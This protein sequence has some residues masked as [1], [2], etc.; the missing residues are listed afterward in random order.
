MFPICRPAHLNGEHALRHPADLAGCTLLEST[1]E[2]YYQSAEPRQPRWAQWLQ[3]AGVPGLTPARYLN[4]TPRALVYSA[5]M[6]G[7]G[8]G[9][10]RSLIVADSLAAKELAVPFG[11]IL[12]QT[13]TYNLVYPSNLGRRRDIAAFRNWVLAEAEASA[14]KLERMLKRVSAG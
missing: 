1:D 5:V 9:L 4:L 11:P 13:S 2:V 10:G 6:A 12:T 7:L 3:A 14:R 8:V